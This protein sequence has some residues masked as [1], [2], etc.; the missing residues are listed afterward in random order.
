MLNRMEPRERWAGGWREW[1]MDG[2]RRC[3]DILDGGVTARE[4]SFHS[5]PLHRPLSARAMMT[6]RGAGASPVPHVGPDKSCQ[7]EL[8]PSPWLHLA[9]ERRFQDPSR[10]S[11]DHTLAW[12]PH[13]S[14]LSPSFGGNP[15]GRP[16]TAPCP[17]CPI[18]LILPC[19]EGL[20]LSGSACSPQDCL[21]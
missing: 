14:I 18:L 10:G 7:V 5:C 4:A 16:R 19:C 2:H 20:P 17:T 6:R 1:P 9:K 21:R 8:T 13:S 3:A 11:P 15:G 12:L